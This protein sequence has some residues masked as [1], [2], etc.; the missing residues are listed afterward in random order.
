ML[1]NCTVEALVYVCSSGWGELSACIHMTCVSGVH[2]LLNYEG[3][4]E[5]YTCSVAMIAN[6]FLTSCSSVLTP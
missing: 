1:M 2:N 6:F 4:M 5:F 3:A